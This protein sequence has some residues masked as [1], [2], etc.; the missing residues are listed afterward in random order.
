MFIIKRYGLTIKHAGFIWFLQRNWRWSVQNFRCCPKTKGITALGM[1]MYLFACLSKSNRNQNPILISSN[2]SIESNLY[3][4]LYVVFFYL[5]YTTYII[6]SY[7]LLIPCH[8]YRILSYHVQPIHLCVY[9][10]T[11]H[12]IVRMVELT[13]GDLGDG[14]WDVNTTEQRNIIIRTSKN[15]QKSL[16]YCRLPVTIKHET[17]FLGHKTQAPQYQ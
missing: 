1:G 15:G 9:P 6:L 3:K 13:Y 10:W 8:V 12:P 7:L 14:L 4:P 2:Q 5:N 17:H 11:T 16:T